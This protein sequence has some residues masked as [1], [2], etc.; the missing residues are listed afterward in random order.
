MK[1]S[2][3]KTERK[4]KSILRLIKDSCVGCYPEWAKKSE[5]EIS[6]CANE[7]FN[8][9]A[10]VSFPS[11]LLRRRVRSD[12]SWDT[13]I[14]LFF[15]LIVCWI[16][17]LTPRRSFTHLSFFIIPGVYLGGENVWKDEAPSE[18]AL[19]VT[20]QT[21][22]PANRIASRPAGTVG[23]EQHFVLPRRSVYLNKQL[24]NWVNSCYFP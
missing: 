9:A 1:T 8:A 2:F 20:V 15:L 11:L 16:N 17:N 7:P 23:N 6:A 21:F 10:S 19:K 13:K 3:A 24:S 12:L 18:S 14:S 5:K 22:S 4:K